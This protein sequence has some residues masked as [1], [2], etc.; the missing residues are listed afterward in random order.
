M[1][2]GQGLHD[3][4]CQ[5]VVNLRQNKNYTLLVDHNEKFPKLM[6]IMM[7]GNAAV[8]ENKAA[9]VADLRLAQTRVQMGAKYNGRHGA[10]RSDPPVPNNS[11]ARGS[12][13]RWLVITPRRIVTWDNHKLDHLQQSESIGCTLGITQ[14]G[15]FFVTHHVTIAGPRF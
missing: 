10:L 7:R 14:R 5:K 6:G 2:R 13:R 1:G 15:L 9:E 3:R 8:L 12:N 11:T 4:P